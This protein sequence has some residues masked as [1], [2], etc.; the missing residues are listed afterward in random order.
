MEA[1]FVVHLIATLGLSSVHIS[2]GD[3]GLTFKD[4][5]HA[6]IAGSH[7]YSAIIAI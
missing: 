5:A 6:M 7:K 1:A 3:C 2:D 4:G